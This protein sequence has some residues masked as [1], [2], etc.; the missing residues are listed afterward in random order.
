MLQG[1]MFDPD[2]VEHIVPNKPRMRKI[3]EE[4]IKNF[5]SYIKRVILKLKLEGAI[6]LMSPGSNPSGGLYP[7]I[8]DECASAEKDH[9]VDYI[10]YYPTFRLFK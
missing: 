3:A 10:I 5:N 4:T 1:T 6:G 8:E 7:K 2:D 9:S